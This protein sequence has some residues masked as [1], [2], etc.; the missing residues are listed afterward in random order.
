VP[1]AH[2]FARRR[3]PSPARWSR[4]IGPMRGNSRT[5]CSNRGLDFAKHDAATMK[6]T[7]VGNPGTMTPTPPIPTAHQPAP[8][9]NQRRGPVR[10]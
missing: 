2:A 7:V 4:T 9:H 6:K 3:M 5:H 1:I 8:N 10:T